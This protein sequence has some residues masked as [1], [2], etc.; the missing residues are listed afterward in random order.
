MVEKTDKAAD[1]ALQ[2]SSLEDAE[3]T[4]EGPSFRE[5][6]RN[7][8]YHLSSTMKGMGVTIRHMFHM[9]KGDAKRSIYTYQ[10]PDEGEQRMAE[11]V[12]ERHRGMIYLEPSKC[13][14]CYACSK[15][16]P[17]QCIVIEGVRLKSD[18]Y[19]TRFTVDNSKCI[20]CGLC[21]EVCPT[22]CIHH[23]REWDYSAFK[24][25]GLV[26]DLL[27]GSVF[28]PQ[29][30]IQSKKDLDQ[31]KIIEGNFK[32]EQDALKAQKKAEEE[33]KAKAQE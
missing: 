5:Y 26:R 27:K 22:D 1:Y 4:L 28:S 10:Y 33:K 18:N 11:E 19:M 30:Y 25:E 24:R 14:M 32:K 29:D 8:K 31:A 16:C 12:A 6:F 23:G 17:A 15:V 13:I 2:A 20:F 7:L 3:D 21:T 9:G